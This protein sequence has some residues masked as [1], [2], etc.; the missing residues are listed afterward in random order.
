MGNTLFDGD[1]IDSYFADYSAYDEDSDYDYNDYDYNDHGRR[2][3]MLHSV[4]EENAASSRLAFLLGGF[5]TRKC[6]SFEGYTLCA[7]YS[8]SARQYRMSVEVASA[9]QP[10]SEYEQ[11]LHR[12]EQYAAKT[13]SDNML[14]DDQSDYD[15]GYADGS[16]YD[17]MS[18]LRDET[19]YFGTC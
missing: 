5:A 8:P 6:H 7:K 10:K 3:R 1:D 11:S 17:S 9:L 2:R 13:L 14:S 12:I 4:D 15:Y 16:E 18:D 19:L